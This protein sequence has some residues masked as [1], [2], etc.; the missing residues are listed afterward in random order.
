MLDLNMVEVMKAEGPYR[1]ALKEMEEAAI[2]GGHTGGVKVAEW[3]SAINAMDKALEGTLNQ[4]E[5]ALTL[6]LKM[7]NM[8]KRRPNFADLVKQRVQ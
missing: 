4:V 8:E 2:A 6:L 7:Q 3:L 1:Q 5:F